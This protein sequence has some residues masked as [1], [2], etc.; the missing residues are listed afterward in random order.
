M[1]RTSGISEGVTRVRLAC[2]TRVRLACVTRVRFASSA[3]LCWDLFLRWFFLRVHRLLVCPGTC[4]QGVCLLVCA[5][6]VLSCASS[7]GFCWDLFLNPS[8]PTAPTDTFYG[9]KSAHKG[10]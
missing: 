1:C 8:L 5:G 10:P 7:T 3:G 6:F 9:L 2:V 4:F